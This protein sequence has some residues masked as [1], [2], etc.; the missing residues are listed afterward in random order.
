[1]WKILVIFRQHIAPFAYINRQK[2][3][4]STALQPALA[5]FRSP[6]L[7]RD[8]YRRTFAMTLGPLLFWV[9]SV[10]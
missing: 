5:L 2:L 1:M 4:R 8:S 6:Y 7:T 10:A 9:N 3:L